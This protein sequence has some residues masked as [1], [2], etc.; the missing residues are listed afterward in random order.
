MRTFVRNALT[1]IVV[2]GLGCSKSPTG[3]S[4]TQF[5]VLFVVGNKGALEIHSIN[6]DGSDEVTLR[7]SDPSID[8]DFPPSWSP[9]GK[10]IVFG[11]GAISVMDG[12][13]KNQHPVVS[14]GGLAPLWSPDGGQIAYSA[15]ANGQLEIFAINANGTNNKNL[16][17]NAVWDVN[18][19]WSPDGGKIAFI[20][21]RDGDTRSTLSMRTVPISIVSRGASPAVTSRRTGFRSKKN[22]GGRTLYQFCSC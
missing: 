15:E 16:T 11:Q 13:G 20:T 22:S 5:R 2:I 4:S 6:V 1:L 12:D 17:N 10:K 8:D 21:S 14:A 9:D 18:P 3:P 7:P 19:A